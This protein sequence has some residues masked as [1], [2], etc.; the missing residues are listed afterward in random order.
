MGPDGPQFRQPVD[1]IS[2]RHFMPPYF[3]GVAPPATPG[4]R[5][6][7]NMPI[8]ILVMSS[9]GPRYLPT[10]VFAPM[11]FRKCEAPYVEAQPTIQDT[12]LSEAVLAWEFCRHGPRPTTAAIHKCTQIA[13]NV[14]AA[15]RFLDFTGNA[16]NVGLKQVRE[17]DLYIGRSVNVC[18]SPSLPLARLPYA[19]ISGT[20]RALCSMNQ[21]LERW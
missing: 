9:V 7:E 20:N 15:M 8:C 18:V 11:K 13:N 6:S 4:S 17:D 1:A 19:H 3:Y 21:F 12:A 5:D 14:A 16:F 2:R 10:R